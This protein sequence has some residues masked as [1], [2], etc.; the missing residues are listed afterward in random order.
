MSGPSPGRQEAGAPCS[1]ESLF[2]LPSLSFLSFNTSSLQ[3]F[4]C[5]EL[6]E[7][8]GEVMSGVLKESITAEQGKFSQ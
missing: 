5:L 2:L 4:I 7:S 8:K 6:T 1:G 3:T